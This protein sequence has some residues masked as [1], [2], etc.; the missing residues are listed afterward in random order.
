MSTA[1]RSSRA[2]ST[3]RLGDLLARST[4]VVRTRPVLL[5]VALV[6]GVLSVVP[7][8]GTLL[9]ALATA[10]AVSIASG[11]IAEGSRSRKD[12]GARLLAFVV[13][14]LVA[15]VAIAVGLLVLVIPGVYLALRFALFPAAVMADGRGPLDGLSAS[16]RRTGGNL[17][18]VFGFLL[19]LFVPVFV[20]LL[21]LAYVVAGG[22][23]AALET[24]SM[25]LLAGVVGA[26]FA[27]VNAAG[28]AVMYRAFEG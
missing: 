23:P 21:V 13:A 7:L 18:L 17:G 20:A 12:L 22:Q 4:A 11:A 10:V 3:L 19:V 5:G 28:V 2:G 1:R 9:N 25:R 6:G 24:P 15:T 27:A 26:P 16:W 14:F 8:L